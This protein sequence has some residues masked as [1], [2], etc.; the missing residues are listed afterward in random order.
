MTRH[1]KFGKR[2]AWESS[3]F[4][5]SRVAIMS[6]CMAYS[7][8]SYFFLSPRFSTLLISKQSFLCMP[9]LS[10]SLKLF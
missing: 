9:I 10:L 7:V 2:V 1:G 5:E 3:F 8:T 6:F 4:V